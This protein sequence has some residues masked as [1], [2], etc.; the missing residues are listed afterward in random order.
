MSDFAHTHSDCFIEQG[1][2]SMAPSTFP[3][4]VKESVPGSAVRGDYKFNVNL[5]DSVGQV[6]CLQ[7]HF[8]IV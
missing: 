7:G 2:Y 6:M 3:I 8:V 1:S 5:S 4:K